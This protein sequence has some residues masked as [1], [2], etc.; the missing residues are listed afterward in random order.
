MIERGFMFC[1][2]CGAENSTDDLYCYDCGAMLKQASQRKA[3]ATVNQAVEK[4]AVNKANNTDDIPPSLVKNSKKGLIII[5]ASVVVII[6]AVIMA[7]ILLRKPDTD[8]SG[9]PAGTQTVGITGE[10]TGINPIQAV[11]AAVSSL[12]NGIYEEDF[13]T[14]E[15]AIGHFIAAVAENDFKGAMAAC[16]INLSAEQYD[17]G[18]Q[19]ERVGHIYLQY[20]APSEYEFY[21]A[22]NRA[23]NLGRLA[24]QMRGFVFSLT[25]SEE[26][27][28]MSVGKSYPLEEGE[29]QAV[30][31]IEE[32]N[33]N[34]LKRLSIVRIDLPNSD[35][36]ES[37][38][39]E[40]SQKVYIRRFGAQ[41]LTERYVLYELD[42]RTYVG[43]FTL[44]RFGD[45]WKIDNLTSIT[46]KFNINLNGNVE[47]ISE[48]EYLRVIVW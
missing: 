10:D 16:D 7:V 34:V 25:G 32:V 21:Q 1:T 45:N 13:M 47:E 30:Q 22:I 38:Q 26:A 39:F 46:S 48:E 33:P 43:G 37:E 40:V 44:L 27:L 11:M 18:A 12:T 23:N 24:G 36:Y 20:S 6:A 35:Y 41:E 9:E 3:A 29:N 5:F 31:F 19:A 14:P 17:T 15:E 4:A 28:A 8:I 42:G 2:K